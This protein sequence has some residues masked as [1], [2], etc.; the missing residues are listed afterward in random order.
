MF[1]HP[2]LRR[3]LQ[4][5]L[6]LGLL[7][8]LAHVVRR[9][10]VSHHT[11]F[12]LAGM[13]QFP[14]EDQSTHF[15]TVDTTAFQG[16][17]P[18]HRQYLT[19][20]RPIQP[21]HPLVRTLA[22]CPNASTGGT[23]NAITRHIRFPNGLYN[24]TF[25]PPDTLHDHGMR[26]FNPAILPLPY[27]S[28]DS[29]DAHGAKYVL[30]SRLVTTGLHQESHVCLADICVPS[31]PSTTEA[32]NHH[33]P[34]SPADD[35]YTSALHQTVPI[36]PR[37]P[38]QGSLSPDDTRPCTDSDTTLLG[39]R[40]GLRCVMAPVKINI[41]PTPAEQCEGAWSAFP[42]LPGFHDPRA[43]WSGKGEPLI[44]V[45]SASRYGCAGLWM[46]DL[47]TI[48]PDLEKV[49]NR[50]GKRMMGQAMSYPHLTEITRNPRHS[51]SSVEKN[52]VLWFPER[53]D[54]YVQYELLGKP[55]NGR[56]NDISTFAD[57]DKESGININ[58][59]KLNSN[60]N[61][62]INERL[63]NGTL[64]ARNFDS[65]RT[66][67]GRGRS[68]AKLIGSGLTST[69][70]THTDEM[71]CFGP[72]DVVDSL[73]NHGHWHQGSNSLRLILCTRV[74][75]RRGECAEDVAVE[76]GR[77]VHIAIVHRKFTNDMK[78][79]MRYERYVVVWESR[80]PF[81]LLAVSR[82]PLL[83]SNERAHPWTAEQNWPDENIGWNAS[84][85]SMWA[86]KRTQA[87][88]SSDGPVTEALQSSAYFMYTPSLAWAWRPR[89]TSIVAGPEDDVDVETMSELG[90]GYLGDDLIVGIGL[91]DVDQAFARIKVD[92]LLHCMRICPGV[93]FDK[94]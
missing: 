11:D 63:K 65:A 91:D 18:D 72:E 70:L 45:N 5:I 78:L 56:K 47:R 21:A 43:F 16:P 42:D 48:F 71:P 32:A 1:R 89:S 35:H 51:R 17:S 69:N 84:G 6:T 62:K 28:S 30:I 19:P 46:V 57:A 59:T 52:W 10:D 58:S 81:Q 15:T 74:Q 39:P 83:M 44:L 27:W 2:S 67:Q 80:A 76:E 60:T 88:K 49:L 90:T 79:P 75:V 7:S 86:H 36:R 73:G 3:W 53:D 41:P 66:Q 31:S 64:D 54:A 24:I 87:R 38:S 92:D 8:V 55:Q 12:G 61:A 14:R 68:F 85:P 93:R 23:F 13:F 40:G 94:K 20:P 4:L 34:S 25:T 50:G 82:W 22:A 26:F 29:P 9:W 33:P 77:S 37:G